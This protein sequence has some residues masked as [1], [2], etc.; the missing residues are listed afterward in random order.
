MCRPNC[1]MYKLI[2]WRRTSVVKCQWSIFKIY[3]IAGLVS[4]VVD[5]KQ[6]GYNHVPMESRIYEL[7]HSGA[8]SKSG[9]PSSLLSSFPSQSTSTYLFSFLFLFFPSLH[10]F[11]L[12]PFLFGVITHHPLKPARGACAAVSSLV[13]GDSWQRRRRGLQTT[14]FNYKLQCRPKF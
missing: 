3:L 10:S 9:C 4:V 2:N 11:P 8:V 12:S 5:P 1:H 13:S 14:N 7:K 6:L